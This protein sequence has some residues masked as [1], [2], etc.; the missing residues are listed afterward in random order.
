MVSNIDRGFMEVLVLVGG[1]ERVRQA[2]KHS[3][4]TY[5]GCSLRTDWKGRRRECEY[6]AMI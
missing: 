4:Q 6:A 5:S 2:G 1:Y 3:K